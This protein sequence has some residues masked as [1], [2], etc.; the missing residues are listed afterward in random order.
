MLAALLMGVKVAILVASGFEQTEV[1][2]PKKALEAEG[3]V[4]YIVSPEEKVVQGWDCY[5]LKVRDQF[6]VDIVLKN[7]KAEDFDAIIIP[8]PYSLMI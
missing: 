1:E 6:P 7:A 8:G 3:A 4:V 5:R 2:E